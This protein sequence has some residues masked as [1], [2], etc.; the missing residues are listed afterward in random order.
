MKNIKMPNS[1][2]KRSRVFRELPIGSKLKPNMMEQGGY[3][4]RKKMLQ[5]SYN[6]EEDNSSLEEQRDCKNFISKN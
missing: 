5:N 3:Y 6:L 2:L 1:M 4:N